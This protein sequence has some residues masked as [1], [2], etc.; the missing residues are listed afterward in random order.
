MLVWAGIVESFLS[1]YHEPVIPYWLK[2]A[3]RLRGTGG[4]GLV[5]RR[6]AS[7]CGGGR[8]VNSELRIRTPEGIIFSY[9]L[10]GPIMRCLAW[11]VDLP[12]HRADLT[13]RRTFCCG[14]VGV[15]SC[16]FAH[17]ADDR[18]A[19]SSSRSATAWR[20]SGCGAGR[21][22]GKRLLRLRVMD[23]QGLRLQFHQVL[24]R[25]L[26]RFVDM[27]PA[28]Y[29]VGGVGLSAEPA[30]AAARRSRG[31]YR[32]RASAAARA[33]RIS[34]N[35]SPANST[36]SAQH[37]HLEARLRQ[38]VSPDEARLALQALLRRDELEPAA[39]VRSSRSSRSIS[40]RWSPFPPEAVEAMPDEQYVRNVVDILFRTRRQLRQRPARI[41]KSK[42]RA[43]KSRLARAPPAG[44]EGRD[45]RT[46]YQRA[47]ARPQSPR[48]ETRTSREARPRRHEPRV[49]AKPRRGADQARAW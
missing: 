34:I 39:R 37:P 14:I 44:R 45:V 32:G 31:E 5:P 17:G 8:R 46:S 7:R 49:S 48:A 29:L 43:G 40:K 9:P 2:I 28:F 42:D 18:L 21:R 25:N 36:H 20:R 30:R 23:A 6:G 26:L 13:A 22:S 38:R 1:Q 4:A 3:V 35:C 41:R 19:T 11:A 16:D 27:L 47:E 24:M 10:A 15:L 33:S 12:D